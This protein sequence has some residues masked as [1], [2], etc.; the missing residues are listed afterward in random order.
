MGSLSKDFID[1]QTSVMELERRG[2]EIA[3]RIADL[4]KENELLQQRLLEYEHGSGFD[5]LSGLYD[6]GF[7]ICPNEFG[8]HREADCLFC[9]NFLHHKGRKT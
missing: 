9:L 5:A 6:D 2:E 1:W 7:H 4:E 3:R 8:K